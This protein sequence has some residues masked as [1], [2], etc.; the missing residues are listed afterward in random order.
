LHP[1]VESEKGVVDER[2]EKDM[3]LDIFEMSTNTSEPTTELVNKDF[4]IFKCY[5]MD[6]KNCNGRK[7]MKACFL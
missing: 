6:V 1:L 7:N 5:R 2:V 3:S 4:L